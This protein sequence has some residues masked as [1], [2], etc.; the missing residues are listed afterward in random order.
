METQ[1]KLGVYEAILAVSDDISKDG[2]AKDKRNELQKFNFRGI[3]DVLNALS[4]LLAKHKLVI[5]PKVLSRDV[6]ERATKSGGVLFFVT[7]EVEFELVSVKDGSTHSVK[8]FGEAQDSGDKATNKALSAA[9]KY[10]AIQVFCIPVEG[11]DDADND[12]DPEV[13]AK[14]PKEPEA[15]A[16]P[17]DNLISEDKAVTLATMIKDAKLDLARLLKFYKVEKVEQLTERLYIH[18]V[19]QVEKASKKTAA[20]AEGGKK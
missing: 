9:Y 12:G 15:P 6:V 20:P 11:Q 16:D 17:L 10:M 4:P 8:T 13:K 5:L 7:V 1:K 2:I 18:A 3:D 14:T 19:E